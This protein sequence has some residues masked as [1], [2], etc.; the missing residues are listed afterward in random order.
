MAAGAGAV[1]HFRLAKVGAGVWAAIAQDGG[2]GLCNAGIVDLGGTTVVFDSMLTPM[3]G[4]ELRKAARRCTGRDPAVVVNSHWHGDHIRGNAAFGPAV[5]VSTKA[6]RE[7]I[8]TAGVRQWTS[9][10]QQ[11][12]RELVRLDSPESDTPP[13]ER[14]LYRGWFEGTLK[15]PT[16]FRPTAPNVTFEDELSLSGSQRELRLLTYG[17]GHSPSDVFAYLPDERVA[18]LGDLVSIGLHPSAGD[19]VPA[20]W[21]GVLRRI[22]HLGVATAVPG[23]GPVGDDSDVERIEAYLRT[24]TRLA[25]ATR[26]RGD[27]A[28]DLARTEMPAEFRGW[29]FSAF[30]ADNLLRAFEQLPA[31]RLR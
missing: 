6:T 30:F 25:R 28:K 19:G 11:M 20:R 31:G 27:S 26:R 10:R 4:V 18:F 1:P 9:D 14:A 29:K 24:L 7:L 13:A 5:V 3:A 23:H 17:G 22:R 16:P 15:V 2:Y 12:G 8:R 21:A